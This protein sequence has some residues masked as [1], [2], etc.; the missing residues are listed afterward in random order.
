M[1][2]SLGCWS[3]LCSILGCWLEIP[4]IL[5]TTIT[6]VVIAFIFFSCLLIIEQ[7]LNFYMLFTALV[8]NVASCKPWRMR[9]FLK[10]SYFICIFVHKVYCIRFRYIFSILVYL[11]V[12]FNISYHLFR[13]YCAK[14][15]NKVEKYQSYCFAS[16]LGKPLLWKLYKFPCS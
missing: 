11:D 3:L 5:C 8:L 16:T 6:K 10:F 13:I 14:G 4:Y 1:C 2:R 7:L 15:Q 9:C 12:D